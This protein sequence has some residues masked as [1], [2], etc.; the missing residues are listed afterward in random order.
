MFSSEEISAQT[1]MPDCF[2]EVLL[3]TA[4]MR[5]TISSIPIVVKRMIFCYSYTALW[6]N[7]VLFRLFRNACRLKRQN[8]EYA[9]RGLTIDLEN[10]ALIDFIQT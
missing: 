1:S 9:G 10:D 3:K 5:E 4:L 7:C 8:K 6:K 2:G